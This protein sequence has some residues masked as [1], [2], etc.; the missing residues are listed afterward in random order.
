MSS[1]KLTYKQDFFSADRDNN[2][3]SVAGICD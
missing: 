2:P 3:L 1:Q